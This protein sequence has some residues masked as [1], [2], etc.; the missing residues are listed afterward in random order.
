[1]AFLYFSGHGM[2]VNDANYLLPVDFGAATE[3]DVKYKAYPAS[4][5]Q[6][7]LESS[8]A[9]LRVLVLDACR[10]NP[11]RFKRDALG[12]LAAMP[13]NAEGTLIAF[14]TGDD[15]TADDNQAEGNGLYTK[16]LIQ[17]LA[18]PGL[19]LR[20]AFQKAKEDVYLASR[21]T[22]NPSIYNNIVGAYYL[23]PPPSE[24]TQASSARDADVEAWMAARDSGDTDLL[25]LFLKEFPKSPYA[26][27]ARIELAALRR[28]ANP[29]PTPAPS[30]RVLLLTRTKPDASVDYLRGVLRSKVISF[31]EATA[32]QLAARPI[33]R[34]VILAGFS[35]EAPEFRSAAGA[36]ISSVR[37]GLWLAVSGFGKMI[38]AYAGLGSATMAPWV[39]TATDKLAFAKPVTDSPLF[40][41]IPRWDP[42]TGPNRV[43]QYYWDLA[44]PGHYQIVYYRA[45]ASLAETVYETWSLSI[46]P[47]WSGNSV[48]T[49]YCAEWKGCRGDRSVLRD[50]VRLIHVGAGRIFPFDETPAHDGTVPIEGVFR[51]GPVVDQMLATFVAMGL[52]Q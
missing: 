34:A 1:L 29:P 18:T 42:P 5:I 33:R 12:G 4:R 43:E 11:F 22:Q 44:R 51:F 23:A 14:A 21:K 48:E 27:A 30:I 47:G 49:E 40:A 2:Q 31:E 26:P 3:S 24:P 13:V 16:Y 46:T 20:E 15:N 38:L 32:Q 52:G 10:N 41:N 25:E 17:A 8:G 50:R 36:I 9:R 19:Q 35:E 39:P 7:K 37:E 28:S 45:P 6:E